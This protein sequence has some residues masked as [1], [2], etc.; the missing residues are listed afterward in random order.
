MSFLSVPTTTAYRKS[1]ACRPARPVRKSEKAQKVRGFQ[2]FGTYRHC[3][4]DNVLIENCTT[5]LIR[6]AAA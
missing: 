6:I 3:I 4:K 1:T 5:S 2:A